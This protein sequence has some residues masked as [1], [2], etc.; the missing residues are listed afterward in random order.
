MTNTWTTQELGQLSETLQLRVATARRDGS[1]RAPVIVWMVRVGDE[2]YTRSVNGP[3]A[4]WFR[5]TRVRHEGHVQAGA[6]DADVTFV[7][8]GSDDGI[9]ADIDAA[10]RAKYHQY[11]S[12]VEHITSS[13]AR[14]TTLKLIPRQH[15]RGEAS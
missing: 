12:P 10:Y 15:L 3:D 2:V 4:A 13:L 11:R 9:H 5:G 6:V 7:D 14:S 1:M 8:V